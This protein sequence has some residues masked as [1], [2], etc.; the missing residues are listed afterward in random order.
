MNQS[1]KLKVLRIVMLFT[2]ASLLVATPIALEIWP[3]GF[4]WQSPSPHPAYEHM[5]WAMFAANGIALLMAVKDPVR[6]RI[7]ID[8]TIISMLLHGM[9][10]AYDAV[11]MGELMHLVGD[12][13]ALLLIA[14]MFIWLR[15]QEPEEIAGGLEG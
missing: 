10:M 9:A 14:V 8:F 11:A 7:I 6:N 15:P 3:A 2:G 13:P 1:T 4:R 5:I 12:V